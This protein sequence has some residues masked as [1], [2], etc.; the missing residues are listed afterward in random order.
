MHLGQER[1]A[2]LCIS[3]SFNRK[4]LFLFLSMGIRASVSGYEHAGAASSEAREDTGSPRAGVKSGL[5][6]GCE[7]PPTE[8][9]F[10]ATQDE[11][12]TTEPSL[13]PHT[14]CY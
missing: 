10:S 9:R 12:I 11:L 2:A 13:Q 3:W 7:E 14:S 4:S 5:S 8:L 6:L 1:K